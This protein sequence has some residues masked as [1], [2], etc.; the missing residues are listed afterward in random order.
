[1]AMIKVLRM[2]IIAAIAVCSTAVLTACDSGNANINEVANTGEPASFSWL[3]I[4]ERAIEYITQQLADM[5]EGPP[6]FFE[7]LGFTETEI[8]DSQL[9]S[10][11]MIYLFDDTGRFVVNDTNVFAFP[12]LYHSDVIG[13]IETA[14]LPDAGYESGFSFSFGKSFSEELNSLVDQFKDED[15][16][17][18]NLDTRLLFAN[19]GDD[20][21]VFNRVF[22]DDLTEEQ[23]NNIL[24][25]IRSEIG[26]PHYFR[27][28][29]NY[30]TR[31]IPD[32]GQPPE[33]ELLTL[34]F[35]PTEG[36]SDDTAEELRK[37]AEYA[38]GRQL[39]ISM[40][41]VDEDYK[42]MAIGLLTDIFSEVSITVIDLDWSL[43]QGQAS[44]PIT[45]RY[46]SG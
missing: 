28:P 36:I 43:P 38:E 30:D 4:R 17:I 2:T 31:P 23:T 45:L 32:K 12:L 37:F 16:I 15:L 22:G 42:N 34:M 24:I 3:S 25:S 41:I 44:I 7:P 27:F 19:I 21:V 1:M 9:G 8:A 20:I 29:S 26:N 14:Y 18:G 5:K 35:N 39:T 10:P 33:N 6:E 46:I 40:P 13:I 11:F